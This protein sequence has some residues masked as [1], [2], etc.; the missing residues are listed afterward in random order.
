MAK[1]ISDLFVLFFV[2]FKK[3]YLGFKIHSKYSILFIL[4]INMFMSMGLVSSLVKPMITRSQYESTS[5]VLYQ[6][7]NLSR[8]AKTNV[9]TKRNRV[10][11]D[12]L[13]FWWILGLIQ[14]VPF[15][16]LFKHIGNTFTE[17]LFNVLSFL[18]Q[19]NYT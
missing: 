8:N 13:C 14:T 4:E 10:A 1:Q 17:T 2:T 18:I 12:N 6:N 19:K 3:F 11:K 9:S 15:L 16:N 5:F 7:E